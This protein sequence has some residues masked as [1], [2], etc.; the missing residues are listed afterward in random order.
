VLVYGANGYTGEL[1]ARGAAARGLNVVL[2]G[3]R[4]EAVG[5][6]ATEMKLPFRVAALDDRPALDAA[7]AGMAAVLHCAGPFVKTSAAMIA[8]CLRNG[9]H[10]LDITG[11]IA[12]FEGAALLDSEAKKAGVMLMPGVGYDVVPSDCLALHL[13]R[14]L[15]GATSLTLAM[16]VVGRMSHGTA[17]TTLLNAGGAGA[18]RK[19]G[20]IIEVPV[21]HR[22]AEVD[23]GKGPE[24][25]VAIPWGDVSTAFYSTG[26][27]TV[28]TLVCLPAA[29][30]FGLRLAGPFGGLIGS[31]M[32]Q[33]FL[34]SRIPAGGPSAEERRRGRS[35]LWGEVT[36]AAGKKAVSRMQTVEGYELTWQAALLIAEKVVAGDAPAGFQTPAK[37]YGPDLVLSIPGTTREDLL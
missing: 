3:R 7:L 35:L 13:K 21:G 1:I 4:R 31:P 33:R 18:M 9:V 25:A 8:G 24:T 19:D 17:S 6:L 28:E 29:M 12:V 15:P 30:R 36:D 11:E 26:I 32:V 22:T 20:R 2:A 27:P 10:Y 37:A 23:F 14:R 5:P 16:K 34:Q